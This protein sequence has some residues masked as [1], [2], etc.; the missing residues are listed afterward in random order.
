M[1]S[2]G[3]WR[4]APS[5]G[6]DIVAT[7]SNLEKLV[8]KGIFREDL[9]YRLSVIQIDLPPLRKRAED[10]PLLVKF[11]LNKYCKEN[12][13][14]LDS[15]G[16]SLLH[17][18]PAAMRFLLN[19]NWPGN[20]RELE[21]VIERV[22]VLTTEPE[23]G[24]ELLPESILG[25][26]SAGIMDIPSITIESPAGTSLFEMVEEFERRVILNELEKSQW[27]QT[28]AAKRLHVALSTLNQKI[29]RL[30][31]DIK[32]CREPNQQPNQK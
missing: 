16:H 21:N 25:P 18:A 31:I 7:S 2:C 32:R 1:R 8:R 4:I 29:Q 27:V 23:I 26:E 6:V 11:F 12:E 5:K 30:Q 20:V 28:E 19:H 17:F 22:T 15:T 9:Y 13:R 3:Y 14:F 24:A 10:I